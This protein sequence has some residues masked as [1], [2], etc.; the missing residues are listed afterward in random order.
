MLSMYVSFQF[1]PNFFFLLSSLSLPCQY[2]SPFQF[3]SNYSQIFRYLGKNLSPF[4]KPRC[5]LTVNMSFSMYCFDEQDERLWHGSKVRSVMNQQYYL[6]SWCILLRSS[7]V[8]QRC[9]PVAHQMLVT[10]PDIYFLYYLY[11]LS[12]F[13]SAADCM[14]FGVACVQCPACTISSRQLGSVQIAY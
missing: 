9:A 5:N 3:F 1:Q 7:W 6:T 2:I 4:A 13:L 8:C 10:F 14:Y 11:Y 12:T